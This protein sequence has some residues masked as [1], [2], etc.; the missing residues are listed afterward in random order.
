VT[1]LPG[2]SDPGRAARS[3]RPAGPLPAQRFTQPSLARPPRRPL[4]A[5]AAAALLLALLAG[6]PAALVAWVGPP[7]LPTSTD[8]LAAGL[9]RPV[10]ADVL[11]GVL[12]LVVW[13]AWLQFVVSVVVEVVAAVRGGVLA[14]SLPLAGPSQRL[15]R[16]LVAAV[17]LSSALAAQATSASAAALDSASAAAPVPAGVSVSA[18]ADPAAADPGPAAAQPGSGTVADQPGAHPLDGKRVY[19]VLA[20][21]G[22]YHDN[23]W[24]IAERCLGDGRR[25]Q[26][27]YDLNAGREQPDGRSLELARLIQPGWQLVMP[28]DAVGVERFAAPAPAEAPAPPLPDQP[29]QPD[30]PG[31]PGLDPDQSGP[32]SA[33]GG[34]GAAGGGQESWYQSFADDPGGTALDAVAAVST[35]PAG[36][37]GGGLLAASVA[38]LVAVRRRGRG[39]EPA[40]EAAVATEVALRLAADE[41]RSVLVD[42]ALRLLSQR[43]AESGRPVPGAYLAV[44][45][46]DE[47][48][49][50]LSPVD[51]SP[52]A[53][54]E[55]TADGRGWRLAGS[56]LPR[57]PLPA[58]TPLP[59]LVGIGRDAQGRDVLLDLAA[60]GGVVA[61]TGSP[62]VVREVAAAVAVQLAVHPWCDTAEIVATTLPVA[63]RPAAGER[64]RPAADLAELEANDSRG[65]VDDV[66]TGMVAAR[67]AR[68]PLALVEAP[69]A[70]AEQRALVALADGGRQLAG[71]LALGSVPCA[72]WELA[73]DDAGNLQAPVLG[74]AVQAH[75]LTED[76]AAGVETLIAAARRPAIHFDGPG[77]PLARPPVPRSPAGADDAA[78]PAAPA[79]VGLLGPALVRAPG[80][81][82]PE[83]RDLLKEIVVHLAAHPGGVHPAVLA[84]A[85]WPRGVSD[86]VRDAAVARARDWLGTDEDGNHRLS[87]AADGRL[88][89]R[90]VAVDLDILH[91]LLARS[92]QEPDPAAESAL[93]R[94]A[95]RLVRGEM[96]HPRPA[97]RF[98]WLTGER[99]ERQTA[100]LVT[101]AA[102]RLAELD[103]DRDPPSASEAARSGLQCWPTAD[104]CWQDL[105]RAEH[106]TGGRAAVAEAAEEMLRTYC[107]LGVEPTPETLA[108]LEDLHPSLIR[109][110]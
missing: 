12:A 56:A 33:A 68:L 37:L 52:P 103:V 65:G 39:G 14:P 17:L 7:P 101:D 79:R 16:S 54:W 10:D 96:L 100:E 48:E 77:G 41:H 82:D 8:G 30:Q 75:R 69:V 46:D 43:C 85:V 86:G 80:T 44:V 62:A 23:L 5:F 3:G 55:P 87:V 58:A 53:P 27:I 61:L 99:L 94:R 34:S 109:T 6:V 47:I 57:R 92:R 35:T 42:R 73:V 102:H 32:G 50:R 98:T 45:D 88:G 26:E 97:A 108:L 24:D 59:Y 28:E 51:S 36:W 81:V 4:R 19:T 74:L 64:L 76:Q 21:D 90:D 20:P 104:V 11:L 106:R 29:D 22:R 1:A 31:A 83:R 9:T 84:A 67:A 49:L 71:V 107:D 18:V 60:A 2:P 63:A 66:L 89:L 70:P 93:L 78:W 91:R 72:R 95:L 13:L 40:P 110:H 105:L 15:A 38:A 25:Y